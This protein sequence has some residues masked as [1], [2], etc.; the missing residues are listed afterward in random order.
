MCVCVLCVIACV[1]VCCMYVLQS[2]LTCYTVCYDCDLLMIIG[3]H[4]LRR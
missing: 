3:L 2:L 4:V 1:C